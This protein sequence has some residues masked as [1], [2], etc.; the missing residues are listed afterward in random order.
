MPQKKGPRLHGGQTG[1]AIVVRVVPGA[2][3]NKISEILDDGTVVV[4]LMAADVVNQA[5]VRFLAEVLK[6]P[7]AAVE[8]VAGESGKDKLVTILNL[9]SDTTHNRIIKQVK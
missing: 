7:S 6:V 3:Q 5:L 9:D 8:I 4:Q 1:A 2:D